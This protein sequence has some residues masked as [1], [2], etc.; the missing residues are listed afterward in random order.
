MQ[1]ATA[2]GAKRVLRLTI[3]SQEVGGDPMAGDPLPFLEIA[4]I[5]L[6]LVSI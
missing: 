6:P 2:T 4:G 5:I 3:K 1:K